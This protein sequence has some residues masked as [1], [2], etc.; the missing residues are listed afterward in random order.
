FEFRIARAD[1]T[2]AFFM[3]WCNAQAPARTKEQWVSALLRLT[4]N[5]R[6]S[7]SACGCRCLLSI[8]RMSE[9]VPIECRSRRRGRDPKELRTAIDDGDC[10]G[11]GKSGNAPVHPCRT[12]VGGQDGKE[13]ARF[14]SVTGAGGGRDLVV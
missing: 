6:R 10:V 9:P 2:R 3:P 11:S 1:E 8:R 14:T 5:G 12:I 7:H 13:N 4:A